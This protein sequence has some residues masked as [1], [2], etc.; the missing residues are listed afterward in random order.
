MADINFSCPHCGHNLEVDESGAGMTVPCPECS[1][2]IEIPF[3]ELPISPVGE[4]NPKS[5][6]CPFCGEQILAVAVK[7]KHCGEF[8]NRRP[9]PCVP[10]SGHSQLSHTLAPRQRFIARTPAGRIRE[11]DKRVLPLFLLWLF[12]GTLGI[13]AFYAGRH[14]Q[15]AIYI[16]LLLTCWLILPGVALLIFLL[17]DLVRILA[18]TYTDNN[19]LRIT[20]WT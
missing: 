4:E 8:L 20:K 9:P 15:G 16:V 14:G 19:D 6:M 11:S 3:P 1:K 17:V 12:L 2:S 7:C 10:Q 5:V 18:G 13:H